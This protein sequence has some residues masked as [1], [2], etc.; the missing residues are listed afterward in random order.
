MYFSSR[1]LS[2]HFVVAIENCLASSHFALIIYFQST[3]PSNNYI[4]TH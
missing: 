4:K 3:F 1:L 2:I